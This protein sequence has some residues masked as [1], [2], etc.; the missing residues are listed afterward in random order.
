MQVVEHLTVLGVWE[1]ALVIKSDATAASREHK[2]MQT[3]LEMSPNGRPGPGL[4]GHLVEVLKHLGRFG[5]HV[6]APRCHFSRF[7]CDK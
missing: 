2:V 6:D 1:I 3:K 5:R 7:V 4:W